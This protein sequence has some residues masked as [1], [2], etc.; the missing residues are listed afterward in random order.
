MPNFKPTPKGRNLRLKKEEEIKEPSLTTF[1]LKKGRVG[2]A[3]WGHGTGGIVMFRI[4]GK[5]T[6][7]SYK[8][9][10]MKEKTYKSS[11]PK[12]VKKAKKSKSAKKSAKKSKKSKSAKKSRKH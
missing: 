5:D 7:M 9:Q 1:R 3:V 6:Y 11:K 4:L 2:Y 8:S 12:K 10:G